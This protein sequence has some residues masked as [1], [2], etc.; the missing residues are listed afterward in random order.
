MHHELIPF[1]YPLYCP[2]LPLIII[3]YVDPVSDLQPVPPVLRLRSLRNQPLIAR[4]L[5]SEPH[6]HH[7]HVT[8][9]YNEFFQCHLELVNYKQ[10]LSVSRGYLAAIGCRLV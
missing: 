8:I 9:F 4:P 3:K 6:F 2:Y 10:R 5:V 1:D 7:K